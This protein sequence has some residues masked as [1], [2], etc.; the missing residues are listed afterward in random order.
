ML[1]LAVR[2][3]AAE[4]SKSQKGGNIVVSVVNPGS[5]KTDINRDSTGLS[6]IGRFLLRTLI[7]RSTEEGSRTLVHAAQGGSEAH[8]QYLNNCKVD[9]Y[10]RP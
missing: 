3:L 2:E 6:A 1:L 7:M 4:I 10:V 5:V 8:G 9:Q